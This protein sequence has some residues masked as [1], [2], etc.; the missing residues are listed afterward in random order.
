M[1]MLEVIWRT[2]YLFALVVFCEYAYLRLPMLTLPT[3]LLVILSYV[4]GGSLCF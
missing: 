4:Q 3:A 1:R 2:T